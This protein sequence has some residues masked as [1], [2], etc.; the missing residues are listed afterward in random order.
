MCYYA[1]MNTMLLDSLTADEIVDNMPSDRA[2]DTLARFFSAL[3][4][5]TRLKIVTVLAASTLCVTDIAELTSLNQTTVS[6]QLRILKSLNI[7]ECS[8]QGKVM[9][10]SLAQDSVNGIMELAVAAVN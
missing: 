5:L 6:R 3:S 7:V 10:Y 2:L 1:H 4:D 9:F 8:R